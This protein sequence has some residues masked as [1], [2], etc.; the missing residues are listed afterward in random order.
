[1]KT[2]ILLHEGAELRLVDLQ[3]AE[4]I[5]A[6]LD[7]NRAHL[8]EWLPFVDYSQSPQDTAQFLQSR[9]QQ[10]ETK[11]GSEYVILWKGQIAGMIG[12]HFF[13]WNNKMTSIG[14]WLGEEFTGRGLMSLAT[15][16]LC[17]LAFVEHGLNRVEIRVATE[18][19]KS[20]AIPTRLGF[21]REGVLRQREWLYDHYV[22]HIMFSMLRSEWEKR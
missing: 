1:M 2:S 4:E 8:R 13:D 17:R 6:L 19:H 12:Y 3:D 5:Y 10:H 7:R 9:I 21:T 18:N 14:Y 15:Q 11:H 16:E 20:Q 22:D